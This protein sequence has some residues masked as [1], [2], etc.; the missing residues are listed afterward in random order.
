MNRILIT[1]I[2]G[3]IG[4][5]LCKYLE[6]KEKYKI[7]G[8]DKKNSIFNYKPKKNNF[9][10][11][12]GNLNNKKFINKILAT[13]NPDIIVH[14]AGESTLDGIKNKKKYIINNYIATKN[15]IVAM[16]KN[17]I[18]N[19][20]FS[21]TASVYKKNNKNITEDSKIYPNNI[22]GL[23]KLNS[24]KI[25]KN[26]KNNINYIIFRFFNVCSAM[27]SIKIGEIHS[28]ETHLVPLATNKIKNKK[29]IKIYGNNFNTKDGTCIRDYIHV[30]DLCI[31]FE[32]SIKIL[33]KNKF[34][35]KIFNL[36]TGC[37]YSVLEV[38]NKIISKLKIYNNNSNNYFTYTKAR[39]GDN[40]RLVSNY[41]KFY[42]F[43]RWKPINSNLSKIISDEI[44]WQ[45]LYKKKRQFIY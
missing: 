2:S 30:L 43:T 34:V 4:S 12:K 23:T 26:K 37:G 42:E 5:C 22:Y 24:E 40:S 18:K 11:Y 17:N 35:N 20:I 16:K 31:A 39:K 15:L 8:V 41:R 7:F 36:G 27:P 38:L 25:I 44:T 1:G 13:V 10:F 33:L 6:E 9:T 29:T 19:L 14:L 28:P 21:S 45:K 32:K 3:Y